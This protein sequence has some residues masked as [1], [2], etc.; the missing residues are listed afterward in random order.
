MIK[1]IIQFFEHDVSFWTNLKVFARFYEL[2]FQSIRTK[3][4]RCR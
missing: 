3:I 1:L 4:L 2:L